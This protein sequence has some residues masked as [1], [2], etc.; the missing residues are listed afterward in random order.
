MNLKNR[1][2]NAGMLLGSFVGVMIAVILAVVVTDNIG[3]T[4][5]TSP[6]NTTINGSARTL[7]FLV[8]LF[9]IIGIIVTILS[10]VGLGRR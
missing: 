5:E 10:A 8:P 6:G 9:V 1:K 4:L 3:T 7:A 2:G